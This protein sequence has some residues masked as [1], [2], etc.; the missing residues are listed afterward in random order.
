[1]ADDNDSSS[2]LS[3]SPDV[4]LKRRHFLVLLSSLLG[5]IA[6]FFSAIPFFLALR[7]TRRSLARA[8]PIK[9]DLRKILPGK[10]LTVLWNGKPIWILKRTPEM[11]AH[12]QANNPKLRDPHSIVEQQPSYA[13]NNCRS[14]KPD[15]GVLVGICTHLGCVPQYQSEKSFFCPCHGSVFDLAGRVYKNV[16]APINLEVPSYRYLDDDHIS[17]G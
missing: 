4:N 17:I 1:M 6:V 3:N 12:L 5:G 7:P 15:I 14:R 16:P 8:N 9:V 13:K 11:I 2:D 10:M